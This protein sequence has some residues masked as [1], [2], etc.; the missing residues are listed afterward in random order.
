MDIITDYEKLSSR[1]EEID[2]RK[3]NKILRE[4]ILALKNEI[5]E[6][7]L[8]GLAAPQIGYEKRVFVINFK[9]KLVTYV[10]PVITSAKGMQ[11][12]RED[13]PSFPDKQF[14]RPRYTEIQVMFQNP[15][16]KAN[17]Q[18][19][20]G[21]ASVIFQELIDHLD[22][23]LLPDL[24]LEI[25]ENFDSATDD[26]RDAVIKEYLNSLDVERK[27]I[28]KEIEDDAEARQMRDAV[29]FMNSVKQ[30]KTTLQV[31]TVKV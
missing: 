5:S 10:N 11:L 4:I 14:I 2:T 8:T 31:E 3:D 28:E 9:G 24:S 23:L 16:G 29:D 21:L 15:M 25:D 12:S 19:L 7:N 18:K 20:V 17:S 22:G 1:S 13:C 27:N 30:G 6:R 26:E